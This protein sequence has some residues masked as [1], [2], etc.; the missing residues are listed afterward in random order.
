MYFAFINKRKLR[1]VIAIILCLTV[2][3]FAL[4]GS[5][6]Y[7]VFY[8]NNLRKLPIY[9]V[10]TEQKKLAISFDCAWGVDYTDKLLD[11]MAFE[12]VKC[13]FF[14]VE[15]WTKK[16]PEYV[17]K[18]HGLGHE[19]GTHSATH[20][21]MSKLSK[22]LITKEL[23]SSKKAIEEL[24]GSEIQVFRPPFGEYNDAVI[25]VAEN[26]GL[27]VIQ[28]SVDSLDWKDLSATEITNRVLDRVKN[29]SI[30]LFHNQGL[31][32]AEAIP[33]IIKTLKNQGYE[34]V[35]IG[36]LIYKE[37]YMILPDGTQVL[38]S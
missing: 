20:P 28:W 26:L 22:E 29:G 2:V 13:T 25:E 36:E 35:T 31:H 19:L 1:K 30:V 14:T 8:G 21:H 38:N 23:T 12:N 37:N 27:Y 3:I 17:K 34:F 11:A 7:K 6:A 9:S 10:K 18:I 33:V 16:Y 24:T 5:G 32:T 4:F 15:F